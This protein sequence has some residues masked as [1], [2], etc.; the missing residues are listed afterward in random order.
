[1]WIMT[2]YGILMPASLP[3]AHRINKHP[4]WDMQVRSRDRVTL[5]KARRKLI[6]MG[7]TVSKI[8]DTRDMDYEWRFY[9]ARES[10]AQLMT[11]EIMEIDYTKF[12][13]TTERRG[14][15]GRRLHDLYD[16]VWYVVAKHYGSLPV[17]RRWYDDDEPS[18]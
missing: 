11:W 1:M 7:L 3:E 4:E 8:R 9:T 15:G 5:V 17:R 18:N 2:S 16:Y 6:E 13:P 14:G 12:K 10:L